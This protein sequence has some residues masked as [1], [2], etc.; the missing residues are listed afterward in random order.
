MIGV[1][2]CSSSR[3]TPTPARMYGRAGTTTEVSAA[4]TRTASDARTTAVSPGTAPGPAPAGA[5]AGGRRGDRDIGAEVA[6]LQREGRVFL[7][8]EERPGQLRP[9]EL[10][11]VGGDGE[12]GLYGLA[13]VL[14]GQH[15]LD[16]IA[17]QLGA[18]LAHDLAA[19]PALLPQLGRLGLGQQLRD[20][21]LRVEQRAGVAEPELSGVDDAEAGGER[22]LR[23][24][25]PVD[26]D[27]PEVERRPERQ[28]L[29][30]ALEGGRP[31]DVALAAD[32]RRTAGRG[33]LAVEQE[34][35]APR[36]VEGLLGTGEQVGSGL[37][38]TSTA[39]AG[40]RGEGE[41]GE[42]E[43]REARAA[44]QHGVLPV[45]PGGSRRSAADSSAPRVATQTG[46]RVRAAIRAA[47]LG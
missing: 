27:H 44:Q 18:H 22:Q 32:Q 5:S 26:R 33:V 37:P 9:S 8:G 30:S 13:R 39:A 36:L 38:A 42:R 46:T 40:Q 11:T 35:G 4:V 47:I 14:A 31:G 29:E 21:G 16:E 28:H 3:L 7:S 45:G 12:P 1:A 41:Q 17:G 6:E 23:V 10:A 20:A 43:Q 34:V 19:D 2:R 25:G 24:D 15:P